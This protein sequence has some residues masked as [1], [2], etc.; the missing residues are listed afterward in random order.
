VIQVNTM[1]NEEQHIEFKE[2]VVK[3]LAGEMTA[4]EKDIFEKKRASDPS[5][6][7]VYQE[8]LKIWKSVDKLA[9]LG[10]YDLDA[11][12]DQLSSKIDLSP[13]RKSP[14]LLRNVLRIAAAILIGVSGVAGWYILSQGT[15]YEEVALLEKIETIDLSDGSKVT[16]N[17]GSSMKFAVDPSSSERKIILQGEAYFD[18]ARDT[19]RPF[20]VEAGSTVIEVLGTSFNVR[21]YTETETVEVTVNSGLVAMGAKR[22][23]GKQLILN[24]GN[25]GIYDKAKRSLNLISKADPNALAWKT[26]ELVFSE[27]SLAEVASVISHVYQ[28]QL[29]VADSIAS[30]PLTVSFSQQELSAVL[31]VIVNTLDLSMEREEG[32]IVLKGE[33]CE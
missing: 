2:Q 25:S 22:G 26:R 29:R 8:Y 12:W 19:L 4:Q 18:V 16:L 7:L 31:N 27:T 23:A 33:G 10:K 32:V 21:A 5:L 13:A 28:V 14:K 1:N 15:N 9:G 3:Y 17:A 20:V 6:E 24:P 30:C 11:E